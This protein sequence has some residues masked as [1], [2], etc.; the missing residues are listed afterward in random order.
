[1]S[2][3]R[4]SDAEY[5]AD[6]H[7]PTGSRE[8]LFRSAA[9]PA[10]QHDLLPQWIGGGDQHPEKTICYQNEFIDDIHRFHDEGPAYPYAIIAEF[11]NITHMEHVGRDNDAV[12]AN[13]PGQL[14][15]VRPSHGVVCRMSAGATLTVARS[16]FTSSGVTLPLDRGVHVPV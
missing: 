14:G 12:I 10:A 15:F 5:K 2:L 8:P 4:L 13:A 11:A 3:T 6:W 9:P 16:M 1:M 7:E